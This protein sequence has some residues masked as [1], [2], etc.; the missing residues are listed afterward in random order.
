MISQWFGGI[1]KDNDFKNFFARFAVEP[2]KLFTMNPEYKVADGEK[3]A[4]TQERTACLVG[5]S[6]AARYGW[7]L[8]DKV[9]IIGDIFPVNLEF[10]IRAIYD[11]PRDNEN[12]IFPTINTCG[13]AF[14]RGGAT[15]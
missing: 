15:R 7:K 6:L 5:R 8:G 11:A 3:R 9:T 14:R 1:Y 13:R 12:L 4:F 10:T 2:E